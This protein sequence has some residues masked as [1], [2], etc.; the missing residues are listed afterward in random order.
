MGNNNSNSNSSSSSIS[1]GDDNN[2]NSNG[3]NN[4]DMPCYRV[5][6]KPKSWSTRVVLSC[7]SI[8]MILTKWHDG[9]YPKS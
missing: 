1:S 7:L 4:N 8:W 3:G 9:T 5:A 2:N 6:T